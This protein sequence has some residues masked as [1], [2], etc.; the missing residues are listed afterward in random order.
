MKKLLILALALTLTLALSVSVFAADRVYGGPDG[1]S[2]APSGSTGT[3]LSITAQASDTES[4]Y[5]IEV[6]YSALTVNVQASKMYWDVNAL[7]YKV[8]DGESATPSDVTAS[9][10]V[11]NRS[12]KSIWYSFV[13]TDL[14]LEDNNN[15][16]ITFNASKDQGDTNRHEVGRAKA[17]AGAVAG[18]VTTDTFTVTS[19]STDWKAVANFYASYF[20]ENPSLDPLVPATKDIA[21]ITISFWGSAS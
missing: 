11:I 15:D 18:S 8:L 4:R 7:E 3:N 21:T 14:M 12:D 17:K 19:T 10:T 9:I 2:A 5:A 16:G 13:V 1:L 20:A 6:E